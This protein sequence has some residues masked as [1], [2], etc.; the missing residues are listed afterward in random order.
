M[1]IRRA[2]MEDRPLL[3][4]MFKTDILDDDKEAAIF[5]MD[6]LSHGET[7]LALDGDA[8]CGTLTWAQRWGHEDGVAEL[9]GLGVTEPYR[10]Q[11]VA[12]RLLDEFLQRARDLFEEAGAR[13]RVVFI[14]MERNNEPARGFYKSHGFVEEAVVPALYP[15]DDAVV[16]CRHFD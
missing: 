4:N 12:S 5:A 16:W 11:G 7:L 2:S 15:H 8:L 3:E 9:I 1:R 10:R 6:V 13:L 14:F